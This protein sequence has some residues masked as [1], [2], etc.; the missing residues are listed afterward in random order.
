MTPE[1]Q[2]IA[3]HAACGHSL[4]VIKKPIH[5]PFCYYRE[6]AAGYTSSLSDAWKVTEE[7]GKKY[8]SGRPTDSDRVILEP[9][10]APDYLN[11]LNAMHGAEKG[12]TERERL[13]Y[14]EEIG[15]QSWD[16]FAKT[17]RDPRYCED[18]EIIYWHLSAT[19]SQRAKAF[20]RVLNLWKD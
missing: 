7:V 14:V 5:S 19:A 3:I 12:L 1:A 13:Q 8:V 20:L 4:F 2:R 16:E 11:D 10:P 18:R 9:V 17:G 6:N 15:K